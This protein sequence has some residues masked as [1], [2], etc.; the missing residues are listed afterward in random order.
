MCSS[1]CRERR[2]VGREHSPERAPVL[3]V[4]VLDE[5]FPSLPRDTQV[6]AILGQS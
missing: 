5:N 3:N 1:S 4:Q 2:A 6:Y